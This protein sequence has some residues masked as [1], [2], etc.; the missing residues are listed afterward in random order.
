MDEG[1]TGEDKIGTGAQGTG[2]V[3]IPEHPGNNE[4]TRIYDAASP[5]LRERCLLRDRQVGELVGAVCI[6]D[7]RKEAADAISQIGE[8][9]RNLL[10][11]GEVEKAEDRLKT[12]LIRAISLIQGTRTELDKE[13]AV[14]RK[15]LSSLES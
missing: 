4:L 10:D 13:E 15:E 2:A 9:I 12:E 1:I 8:Q 11:R 7:K 5:E 14:L 3:D 6:V